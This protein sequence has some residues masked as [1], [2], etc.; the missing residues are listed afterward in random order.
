MQGVE[1]QK[2]GL[3]NELTEMR[4]RCTTENLAH[5]LY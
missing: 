2:A 4:K 5:C 3:L 1:G